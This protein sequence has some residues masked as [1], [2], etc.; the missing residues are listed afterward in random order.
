MRFAALFLALPLVAAEPQ[1]PSPM[2]EHTRAHPRLVEQHPEGRRAKLDAGTLFIP[3]ALAGKAEA[4]LLVFLHGGA[5]IP[6]A[7][8]AKHGMA[9]LVIQRGD[10]YR[11]LFEKEDAFTALVAEASSKAALRWTGITVGGWSAGCQ[12]IRQMFR[13]PSA[14]KLIDRVVM[15]DGIHTSYL[16]GKP[17]P[18]ESK[19]DTD[20]LKPVAAFAR[21]AMAGRKRLLITHS[22][23]FPGTF[24]STTETADWLLRD[25]GVARRAVLAWGPM[26]TQQLS[27]AASGSFRLLGF[28]GNSA[29]DHVDQL[30]ALSDWLG[31]EAKLAADHVMAG[32]VKV[33]APAVKG[34]HDSEF[35]CLGDRAFIVTEANDRKAG[36]SAG[37]PFIYVTLSVVN[38]K[39]LAVE[40]MIDFARGEQ[41]FENET[42]PAGACFVPR[43]IRKDANTLRCYFTSEEPGK[44][45]S[46][47]WHT[48]FDTA[49][50]AFENRIHRTKLR[51]AA[52]TFDMQPQHFHA[53]A[54]AQGFTKPA[55]DAGLFIF[56]SF[57]Q[58]DGRTCVALN[59]FPGKQ[60]ALAVAND[61]LDTFEIIGHYNEPQELQLSESAVNRLP[62]GTWMAICRQDGGDGNYTFTTSKDG[63]TWTRGEHRDFVPNGTNSKPT[64]DKFRGL[65]YLGWQEATKIGDVNRS[66][67]NIDIS[68][69]GRTWE[70]KYRFETEH[71]FQYPSF[72]EHDGAIWLSVTQGDTDPSRKERIM[73]G[74]LE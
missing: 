34:A 40:K 72:H 74:K 9:A 52:G 17:G 26:K 7:A 37:W 25:I 10:G 41:R 45:Q 30:H 19:M 51:T 64:F 57:K 1:N 20:T 68:R 23:I 53:D 46:Q 65:Y 38:L 42:L 8:A 66:V 60:N 63:R 61:A 49:R 36:E 67:F 12:G 32:L 55:K 73:F 22:E 56:D 18:L 44:R 50:M 6:E 59:N 13:S 71:S 14:V 33:T 58:L 28:A 24:A 31:W 48:D 4:P 39:T 35:V 27:E 43:I 69:D 15:I 5:W 11:A 3:A 62:D 29:P 70:R 21:E 47:M 54:A 16:D 2:V